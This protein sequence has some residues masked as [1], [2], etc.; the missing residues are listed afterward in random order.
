MRGL[1]GV[2]R[3]NR[4]SRVLDL[5]CIAPLFWFC[6][7]SR[8]AGRCASENGSFVGFW[9]GTSSWAKCR[10]PGRMKTEN[11]MDLFAFPEALGNDSGWFTQEDTAKA[12]ERNGHGA[13]TVWHMAVDCYLRPHRNSWEATNPGFHIVSS[14]HTSNFSG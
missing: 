7:G 2:M 10:A 9:V 14:S 13:A 5:L 4:P 12:D 6:F 11:R 3:S 1:Y 8:G